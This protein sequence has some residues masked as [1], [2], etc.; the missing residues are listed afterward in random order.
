MLK[1]ASFIVF[2]DILFFMTWHHF[3]MLIDQGI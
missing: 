3:F 1:L 2:Y